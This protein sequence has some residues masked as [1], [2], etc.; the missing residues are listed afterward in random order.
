MNDLT[1]YPR[2]HTRRIHAYAA[3]FGDDLANDL[4]LANTQEGDLCLD[5]F[6]GAATTLIQARLLGRS[7][8]GIDI[9]PIAPLIGKVSTPT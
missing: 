7:V 8:I 9:D 6:S 1:S 2:L 3:S 5:P 4:I